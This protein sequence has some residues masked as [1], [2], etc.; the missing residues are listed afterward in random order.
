[1]C[2]C[3]YDIAPPD[4]LYD[5]LERLSSFF[6]W[7]RLDFLSISV[8]KGCL[9]FKVLLVL[10]GTLPLLVMAGIFAVCVVVERLDTRGQKMHKKD[11]CKPAGEGSAETALENVAEKVADSVEGR[12][13]ACIGWSSLWH[14][15]RSG[16]Y[17]ALP[18]VLII[19]YYLTISVSSLVFSSW[20]CIAFM[21]DSYAGSTMTYL[22]EDLSVR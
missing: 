1:M 10:T 7:A 9:G 14:L 18:Y 11:K 22:R 13:S 6:D 17:R 15:L 4:E 3:R 16:W 19:A 21:V 2:P 5:V 20:S 12:A 8:P